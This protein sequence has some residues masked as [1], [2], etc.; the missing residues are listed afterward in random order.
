MRLRFQQFQISG[1]FSAICN[2][3]QWKEIQFAFS[4]QVIIKCLSLCLFHF[5]ILPQVP[6]W[7]MKSP[8]LGGFE[9][10]IFQYFKCKTNPITFEQYAMIPFY[11]RRICDA[12]KEIKYENLHSA[13]YDLFAAD[14][15]LK[16][17][18]R[19]SSTENENWNHHKNRSHHRAIWYQT[20]RH[21]N[22]TAVA[23]VKN[24]T[25]RQQ[26]MQHFN[27]LP[28]FPASLKCTSRW[29]IFNGLDK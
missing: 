7:K 5:P 28:N 9:A 26:K 12:I 24:G 17:K 14:C 19:D 20:E 15:S 10:E 13:D 1:S 11:C 2:L 18:A 21:A 29:T 6:T 8:N 3:L 27:R 23:L 4:L 16:S 22:K 25:S